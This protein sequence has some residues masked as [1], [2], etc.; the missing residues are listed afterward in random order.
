MSLINEALERAR[1]E[2]IRRQAADRRIPPP[3]MPHRVAGERIGWKVAAGLMAATLV[4]SLIA[5]SL[6]LRGDRSGPDT[7]ASVQGPPPGPQTASTVVPQAALPAEVQQP[8]GT[9][10]PPTA[11]NPES[12]A[13]R[14]TVVAAEPPPAASGEAQPPTVLMPP[15]AEPTRRSPPRQPSPTIEQPVSGPAVAEP[16]SRSSAPATVQNPP[17]DGGDDG[18]ET[19]AAS[20][21]VQQAELED[22]TRLQLEGIAWSAIGP[23]AL[24]NG[25]VVGVREYVEGY[26]VV[27]ISQEEVELEGPSGRIVIRLE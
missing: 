6:V 19:S 9:S 2:A 10:P 27:A 15:V 14:A 23:F 18:E 17:E 11:T 16:T 24:L 5:L 3:P 22:G 25:R 26:A 1:Q 12:A 13:Q 4:V 21:F 20:V 7:V 8:T